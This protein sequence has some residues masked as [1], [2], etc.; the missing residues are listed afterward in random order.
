MPSFL[1]A[2]LEKLEA[3][4]PEPQK[5]RRTIQIIVREGDNE[6]LLL[7]AHRFNPDDGDFA[8]IRRIV[9]PWHSRSIA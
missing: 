4:M 5:R 8:I 2:R 1:S 7:A 9:N 6:E 3:K